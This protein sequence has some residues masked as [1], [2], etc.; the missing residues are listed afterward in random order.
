MNDFMHC[1]WE[2]Q[3]DAAP[4]W[5]S[6]VTVQDRFTSRMHGTSLLKQQDFCVGVA[7]TPHRAH[8]PRAFGFKFPELFSELL[9]GLNLPVCL[10]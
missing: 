3:T 7:G 5:G 6:C 8:L 1:H 10:G 2:G 9:V 4:Q